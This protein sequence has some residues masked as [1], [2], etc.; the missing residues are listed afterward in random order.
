MR[1]L[2]LVHLRY[3]ISKRLV[4]LPQIRKLKLLLLAIV[5]V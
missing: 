4:S 3:L 5:L 2:N 1:S